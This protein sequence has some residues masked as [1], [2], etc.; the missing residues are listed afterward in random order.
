MELAGFEAEFEVS[1]DDLARAGLRAVRPCDTI[2]IAL[3]LAKKGAEAVGRITKF[4]FADGYDLVS[5]LTAA[6]EGSADVRFAMDLTGNV[7]VGARHGTPP[8][9]RLIDARRHEDLTAVQNAQEAPEPN[10]IFESTPYFPMDED[11]LGHDLSL[12]LYDAKEST[13]TLEHAIWQRFSEA[14][15]AYTELWG[16]DVSVVYDRRAGL[17]RVVIDKDQARVPVHLAGSGAQQV[18]RLLGEL[19]TAGATFVALEEPELNLRLSVQDK[20]RELI[21][22][23][24]G[25]PG[26]PAQI[27]ITSHSSAFESG[28]EFWWMSA[29][30]GSPSLQRV[31]VDLAATYLGTEPSRAP[32]EGRASIPGYLTTDGVL[33]LEPWLMAHI[34]LPTGGGVVTIRSSGAP[35]AEVMSND[36]FLSRELPEVAKRD[37]G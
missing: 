24:V 4:Q 23:L 37:D 3:E 11:M 15:A 28:P 1:A 34:G 10:V 9:F 32:I 26:A 13:E 30:D 33:R 25:K 35:I 29:R 27:I 6:A 8:R 2:V 18:L 16:G 19:L 20:L 21:A 31:R 7:V 36:T 14:V 17:A 22:G 5:P 12:R